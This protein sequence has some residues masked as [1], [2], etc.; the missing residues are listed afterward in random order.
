MSIEDAMGQILVDK[1]KDGRYRLALYSERL[2]G[3]S[4]L[5]QLERGYALIS[6]EDGTAL[7]S[8][9]EV[10]AGDTLNVRLLDGQVKASVLETHFEGSVENGKE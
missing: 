9:Q 8:V 10:S 2:S 4:P 5:K 7:H 1:L 6:R 3:L